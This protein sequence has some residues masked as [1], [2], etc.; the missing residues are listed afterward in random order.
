ME[1]HKACFRFCGQHGTIFKNVWRTQESFGHVPLGPPES[2]WP[3]VKFGRDRRRHWQ[4]VMGCD[5]RVAE[6]LLECQGDVE[7]IC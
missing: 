6:G 5:G 1:G 7:D 2:L 4:D 3:R